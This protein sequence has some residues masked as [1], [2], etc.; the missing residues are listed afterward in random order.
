MKKRIASRV[1]IFAAIGL[2]ILRCAEVG[3]S[4]QAEPADGNLPTSSAPSIG[5]VSFGAIGGP[6]Q[7]VVLGSSDKA[8]GF[9]FRVQL[10]SKGAGLRQATLSEYD[11]LIAKDRPP[12]LLLEPARTGGPAVLSLAN[13]QLSSRLQP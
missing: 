5:R 8:T 10:D 11:D 3:L 7:T 9:K 6:P 13:R 12:L 4:A 1:W 2:G